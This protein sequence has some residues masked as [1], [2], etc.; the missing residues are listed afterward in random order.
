[1]RKEDVWVTALQEIGIKPDPWQEDIL[2]YCSGRDSWSVAIRSGHGTGKTALAAW[3]ILCFMLF[4]D[5]AKVPCTAPTFSQL[6]QVLWPELHK[7]NLGDFAEFLTWEAMSLRHKANPREWFALGRSSDRGENLQGF[8]AQNL[9]YVVDEASGV[10]D[11]I[12]EPVEGALTTKGSCVLLISNP[13]KRTGYF[14][15]AFHKDKRFFKTFHVAPENTR[16][17][18]AYRDRIAQKY[19]KESNFYRVRVLGEFP[20]A[21]ED[22]L[23]PLDVVEACISLGYQAEGKKV[24]AVDPARFGNDLSAFCLRQGRKVLKLFT[25]RKEDTMETTG[26]VINEIKEARA[27]GEE[28]EEIRVDS[29]GLGAGVVDRLNEEGYNVVPINVAEKASNEEEY[30]N[31]RAE[32]WGEGEKVI[33]ARGIEIPNDEDLIGQI[34]TVKYSFD[35]KGRLVIESKEKMKARGLSSPDKADAFLMSLD[36]ETGGEEIPAEDLIASFDRESP[37][38]TDL[39]ENIP[40]SIRRHQVGDRI[41]QDF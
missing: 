38:S 26:R 35:S 22:V 13:T 32:L 33:K 21:E 31:R 41:V 12:F 11:E 28:I 15:N 25:T 16:Q 29:I 1:M 24:L 34:S 18:Q 3:C 30:A 6:S 19:G 40:A 10:S 39:E 9:L 14:F 20:L 4:R 27:T 2:R 36:P 7:W 5:R 23:I 17:S 8:H 37:T